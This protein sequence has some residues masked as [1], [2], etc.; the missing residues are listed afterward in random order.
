MTYLAH[1]IGD[2]PPSQIGYLLA[3]LAVI[4]RFADRGYVDRMLPPRRLRPTRCDQGAPALRSPYLDARQGRSGCQGPC[5]LAAALHPLAAAPSPCSKAQRGR[6]A[7]FRQNRQPWLSTKTSCTFS[8][9]ATNVIK[10]KRVLDRRSLVS[11]VRAQ[12]CQ[13]D[14][15]KAITSGMQIPKCMALPSR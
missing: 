14:Q 3:K 10:P 12:P 13:R 5:R 2:H 8:G 9:C 1:G 4:K 11:A 7:D 6:T 15:H